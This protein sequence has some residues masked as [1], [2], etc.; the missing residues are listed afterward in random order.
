MR[1]GIYFTVA[2]LLA[3]VLA[4]LFGVGGGLILIPFLVLVI[5]YPQQT[6]NGTSL[7]ALLG[8]VGIL[9]VMAYYNSGQ[10]NGTHI[11]AGLLIA[12]GM[13]FGTYFGSKWALQLP[14]LY[15]RRGFCVFL[16]LTA[17]RMWGKSP[18]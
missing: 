2:G 5:G 1:E 9:G 16:I 7:V 6:A 13:F 15:L 18:A 11:R 12:L 4:G 10:I 14:E 3:G 17:L 8:P